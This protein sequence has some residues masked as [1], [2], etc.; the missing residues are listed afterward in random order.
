MFKK[1]TPEEIQEALSVLV[2]TMKS[3][4]IDKCTAWAAASS[5]LSILMA[6]ACTH[7]EADDF[8]A[9]IRKLL[10]GYG[11]AKGVRLPFKPVK[12]FAQERKKAFKLLI[13]AF[14]ENG[15]TVGAAMRACVALWCDYLSKEGSRDDI[16]NS[17]RII[18]DNYVDL[19]ASLRE[20]SILSLTETEK[21]EAD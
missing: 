18:K 21:K 16:E 5:V 8:L 17:L 6:A 15:I 1:A 20:K 2:E 9:A 7:E 14:E 3:N 11:D 12:K 19:Y 13:R 4:G 10:D